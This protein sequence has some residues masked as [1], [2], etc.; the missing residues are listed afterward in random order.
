MRGRDR[1]KVE[2]RGVRALRVGG[3][4]QRRRL[5]P[6][7]ARHTA[8]MLS[9]FSSRMRVEEDRVEPKNS[10]ILEPV[11]LTFNSNQ[12]QD[13]SDTRADR[14]GHHPTQLIVRRLARIDAELATERSEL[15]PHSRR[16]I[17]SRQRRFRFYH[18]PDRAQAPEA[19][20][21]G[22]STPILPPAD[23]GTR[24]ISHRDLCLS[25]VQRDRG[26]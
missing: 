15:T 10:R 14:T 25:L 4:G 7:V 9:R 16:T 22:A 3:S 21:P 18:A 20:I 8:T 11:S 6:S 5:A 26:R 13:G 17:S 23:E 24:L 2:R 1:R 19:G 12:R